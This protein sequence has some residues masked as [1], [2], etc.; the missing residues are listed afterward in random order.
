MKRDITLRS[1]NLSD[2]DS[3]VRWR[4]SDE[5]RLKMHDQRKLT[6]DQHRQYFSEY[7]EN[8]RILQYIIVYGNTPVGTI[9]CKIIDVSI[10]EMGIFITPEQQEK[11]Y[12]SKAVNKFV[13][14]LRK[15]TTIDTLILKV[16]EANTTA[17]NMYRKC[18]FI[19]A[20]DMVPKGFISMCLYIN[21]KQDEG[22]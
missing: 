5:V 15:T 7:V 21:K 8:G 2:T 19:I 12:G 16:L 10:A 3:I 14:L 22:R 11:G 4:N 17:I 6:A 9:F 18:G 13:E 20:K 1:I